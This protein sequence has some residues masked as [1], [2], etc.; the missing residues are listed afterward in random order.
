MAELFLDK[1]PSFS[2]CFAYGFFDDEIISVDCIEG[3]GAEF[4]R[5]RLSIGQ[6]G[7]VGQDRSCDTYASSYGDEQTMR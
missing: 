6:D 2:P 5:V 7:F 3:D 4:F 1:F